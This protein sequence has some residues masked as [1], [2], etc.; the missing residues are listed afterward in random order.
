MRRTRVVS[1]LGLAIG[2]ILFLASE[3]VFAKGK[4]TPPT[5]TPPGF[6]DLLFRLSATDP[7]SRWFGESVSI[8]GQTAVVGAPDLGSNTRSGSAYLFDVTTGQPLRTL[9]ASDAAP[10]VGLGSDVAI[11]GNTA[12]VGGYLANQAY[13]FDVTTGQEL[14]TFMASDA[15]P[16]DRFGHGVALS[17][18]KA[19]GIASRAQPLC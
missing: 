12:L 8:S 4:P 10:G 14:F 9:T 7:A 2:T 19:V 15:V 16:G 11:L 5:P 6:G 1:M 3:S 13:L 17:G 18:N